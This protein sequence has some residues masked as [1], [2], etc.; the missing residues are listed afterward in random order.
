MKNDIFNFFYFKWC[1]TVLFALFCYFWQII[2]FF[3]RWFCCNKILSA[4]FAL[5]VFVF[6]VTPFI[7]QAMLR[8]KLN[9]MLKYDIV[10]L[11][12]EKQKQ[13]LLKKFINSAVKIK[14]YFNIIYCNK[15]YCPSYWLLNDHHEDVF[16]FLL[17]C[18]TIG[19][20]GQKIT[21]IS[22]T[23]KY[24]G[25]G[26]RQKIFVCVFCFAPEIWNA[27][28]MPERSRSTRNSILLQMTFTS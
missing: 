9:T 26:V 17:I 22:N 6:F 14:H 15:I 16:I 21:R 25:L 11:N 18:Q 2:M 3:L 24:A 28:G 4:D 12:R 10:F 20:S 19:P 13:E 7:M 5:W 8:N 27:A 23:A 1:V